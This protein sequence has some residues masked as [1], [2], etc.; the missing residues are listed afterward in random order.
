MYFSDER[1]SMKPDPGA[2][3]RSSHRDRQG[4]SVPASAFPHTEPWRDS[5]GSS[6]CTSFASWFAEQTSHLGDPLALTSHDEGRSLG[7]L[8]PRPVQGQLQGN[9]SAHSSSMPR[10][11]H[12]TESRMQDLRDRMRRESTGSGSVKREREPENGWDFKRRRY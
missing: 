12:A 6:T 4:S 2:D 9:S 11:A 3:P 5:R 10:I 8:P 7:S 1:R